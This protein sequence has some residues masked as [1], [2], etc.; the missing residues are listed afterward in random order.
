MEKITN[1]Q[2][3]N[4][5]EKTEEQG[6]ELTWSKSLER[7]IAEKSF[8]PEQGARMVRKVIQDEIED[9]LAEQIIA[10]QLKNGAKVK[11]STQGKKITITKKR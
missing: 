10:G 6:I 7:L 8:S 9:A 11:I 3:T 4:L 2:L 1:F 5:K